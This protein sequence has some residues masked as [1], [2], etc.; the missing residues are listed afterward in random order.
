MPG[1]VILS[2]AYGM[3]VESADDPFLSATLDGSRALAAALVPGKFLV[4]VFSIC[5]PPCCELSATTY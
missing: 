5:A 3:D 2:V 4:E 1:A